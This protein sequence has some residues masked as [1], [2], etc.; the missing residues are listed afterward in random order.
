MPAAVAFALAFVAEIFL[1]TAVEVHEIRAGAKW[2]GTGWLRCVPLLNDFVRAERPLSSAP[3]ADSFVKLH[4]EGH[5][6]RF[7]YLKRNVAKALMLCFAALIVALSVN[8]GRLN[9]VQL[10]L[11]LH[12]A[13]AVLRLPYHA[14]C[15]SEEYAADAYAARRVQR[16]TALRSLERLQVLEPPHSALFAVVYSEHPTAAMRIARLNALSLHEGASHGCGGTFVR[17]AR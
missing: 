6:R 11:L 2:N 15:F 12:F 8:Y 7:H 13:Y 5:L 4:E 10:A 16:G 3:P 9:L 14:L 1:R 17:K